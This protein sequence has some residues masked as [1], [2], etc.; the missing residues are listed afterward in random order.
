MQKLKIKSLNTNDYIQTSKN[1]IAYLGIELEGYWYNGHEDLKDDSSVQFEDVDSDCNGNCRDNCDCQQYCEC[2]ECRACENCDISIYECNCD[3][4]MICLDCE[5]HFESCECII[6]K[7]CEKLSCVKNDRCDECIESFQENQTLS[8]NCRMMNNDYNNCCMDCDCECSCECD[9]NQGVG[10]IASPKLRVNEVKD[11][12]LNNYPDECNSSCG[13]HI[14]MSFKN[15]KKDYAILATKEFYDFFLSEIQTWAD[16]R[17]INKNSRFYK[18]LEG[19]QY[20][21]RE[22]LAENQLNPNSDYSDRYAHLNFCYNKH[23]TLE[24][25]VGN[26]FDNKEISVEYVHAV[27]DIV[28]YYLSVN[29]TKTHTIRFKTSCNTDFLIKASMEW[30][31]LKVYVKS[32]NY[33]KL[34][35]NYGIDEKKSCNHK[36]LF[37]QSMVNHLP[38]DNQFESLETSFYSEYDQREKIANVNFLKLK[39]LNNG[40]NFYIQG[41]YTDNMIENYMNKL[42]NT[43]NYV[44]E[45]CF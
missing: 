26:M 43:V 41:M 9:C 39:G 13:L 10:E 18:R 2:I 44:I 45:E 11:F 35:D 40:Q 23:K 1:H 14:H 21:K 36:I 5:N 29:N 4:C 32:S 16:N 17:K 34:S 12:I 15:D 6:D 25:R 7:I 28:N 8:H 3:E 22:F 19:V 30:Y 20:S 31:G 24:I 37:Y 38:I 33:H 42:K 27:I